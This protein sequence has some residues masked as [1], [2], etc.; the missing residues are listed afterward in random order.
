MVCSQV[1][2]ILEEDRMGLAEGLNVRGRKGYIKVGAWV[3]SSRN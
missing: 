3:F 1:R 2:D